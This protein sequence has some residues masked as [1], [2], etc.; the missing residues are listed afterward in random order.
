MLLSRCLPLLP[1]SGPLNVP[2]GSEC[3]YSA[4]K[5]SGLEAAHAFFTLLAATWQLTLRSLGHTFGDPD[6]RYGNSKAQSCMNLGNDLHNSNLGQGEG[7]G[8]RNPPPFQDHYHPCGDESDD[9]SG[10][11]GASRTLPRLHRIS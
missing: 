5:V 10:T 4:H 8:V 9:L 7:V 6:V 3:G 11:S 1:D 2:T